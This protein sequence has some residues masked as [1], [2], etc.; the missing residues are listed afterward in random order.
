MKFKDLFEKS[1]N[2]AYYFDEIEIGF[3]EPG[4]GP[5]LSATGMEVNGLYATSIT[6]SRGSKDK[7][8]DIEIFGNPEEGEYKI[9]GKKILKD[10]GLSHWKLTDDSDM[11][12]SADYTGTLSKIQ[13]DLKKAFGANFEE[14]EIEDAIRWDEEGY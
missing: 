3:T 13:K 12:F 5:A 7:K 1:V 4:D 11:S 10:L 9:P 14:I 2:E 8:W 6:L